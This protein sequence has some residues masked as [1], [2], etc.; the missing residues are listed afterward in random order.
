MH[1]ASIVSIQHFNSLPEL[2]G[3]SGVRIS[4]KAPGGYPV[5]DNQRLLVIGNQSF[6]ITSGAVSMTV[7]TFS[8]TDSQFALLSNGMAV[9]VQYGTEATP[10]E[11]WNAGTLNRSILQMIQ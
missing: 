8:L 11:Y 7:A 10:M 2:Q 1:S 9:H 5:R 3:F 4:I 6:T